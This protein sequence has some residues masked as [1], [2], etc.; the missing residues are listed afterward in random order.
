MRTLTNETN[1][2]ISGI[3][4]CRANKDNKT[5]D[6]KQYITCEIICC[7]FLLRLLNEAQDSISLLYKETKIATT[8]N[9]NTVMNQ[10]SGTI[11][12]H[13]EGWI[14]CLYF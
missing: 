13:M 11:Y 7:S 9:E 6:E 14:I 10:I 5:F 2:I 3:A 4:T 1:P 12:L 8:A